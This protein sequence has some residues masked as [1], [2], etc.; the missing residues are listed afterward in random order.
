MATERA[1]LAL[2]ALQWTLGV[3]ILIEA[4]LF[5]M[6]S[7]SRAFSETH[8]PGFIRIVLGWGEIAG[9]ILMLIPRTAARGAWVLAG[10]F[11]LAILIHLLHGLYEVGYLAIYTAAAVAVACGRASPEVR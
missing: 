9:C 11:V 8:M 10:V 4:I 2:T 7:G 5:V 6:P 3:V 1:N